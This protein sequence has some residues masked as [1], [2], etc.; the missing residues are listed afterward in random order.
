MTM[1]P[2]RLKEIEDWYVTYV[3]LDKVER[4]PID[5]MVFE[6]ID[7]LRRLRAENERLTGMLNSALAELEDTY[8]SARSY[9]VV[10]ELRAALANKEGA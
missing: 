8:R 10:K 5:S 4:N 2:E 1:T 7:E 6:L 3:T 9:M